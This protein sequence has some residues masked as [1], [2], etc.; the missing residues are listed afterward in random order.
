MLICNRYGSRECVTAEFDRVIP[1]K[2]PMAFI[3][4]IYNCY[5]TAVNLRLHSSCIIYASRT[6]HTYIYIYTDSNNNNNETQNIRECRNPNREYSERNVESLK[7]RRDF[8]R[9]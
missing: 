1:Y 8:F 2:C 4:L 9:K 7:S 6:I 3:R 5:L